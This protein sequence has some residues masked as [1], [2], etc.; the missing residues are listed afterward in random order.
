M[1]VRILTGD[2]SHHAFDDVQ[3]V[4]YDAVHDELRVS[5]TVDRVEKLIFHESMGEVD[6]FQV[7]A[8]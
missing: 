2:G 7:T 5:Q 3:K 1:N 4:A 6:S 8:D